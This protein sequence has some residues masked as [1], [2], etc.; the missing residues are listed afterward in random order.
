MA[1]EHIKRILKVGL[2]RESVAGT[3]VAATIF[4]PAETADFM[5]DFTKARDK[6]GAGSIVEQR[7]SRTVKQK[8]K[9]TLE[10]IGMDTLLGH[11]L[12]ATLGTYY[13]CLQTVRSGGSGT[14]VVG[15]T[16]TQ[17]VSAATGV[18]R[19]IRNT[20]TLYISVTSGTF[21]S[22]SNNI[23]GGTSGATGIITFDSAIRAHVFQLL[24]TNNHPSYTIWA[25]DDVSTRKAAYGM[26]DEL[27]LTAAM[28]EFLKFKSI[29]MAKK[30]ATDTV[31]PAYSAE[32]PFIGKNALVYLAASL[33]ALD[34]A[35]ATP[36]SEAMLTVK[37][38]VEDYQA[39]G[40]GTDITSQHNKQFTVV[41]DLSAIFNSETLKNLVVNSTI[42]A[43]RIELINSDVVI[44]SASNP[45][46]TIDL[47]QCSFADWSEEGGLDDL[48][49]Q[50]VGF[51]SE[52]SLTDG[53]AMTVIL[54]NG[55][56]TTY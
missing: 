12:Y 1:N 6:S 9:V 4:I 20:T 17:A 21:T 35:S 42:D 29:W 28:G 11:L 7:A 53:E 16:V 27:T 22:G 5:P 33:S 44:G 8:S 39:F 41:G 43:M 56:T 50:K 51:E 10:G 23:T 47:A 54:L 19:R 25:K 46:L 49:M 32:N 13:L 38:N 31:T 26:L 45:T 15:E 30:E 24:N 18:V 52:L 37:K 3:P 40:A 36:L 48:S 14:F 2:G 55:K 34:A